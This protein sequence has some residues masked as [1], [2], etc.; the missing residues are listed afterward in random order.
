MLKIVGYSLLIIALLTTVVWAISYFVQP[1]LPANINNAGILF[2][3]ALLSVL[4]ALAAFKDIIELIQKF[5]HNPPATASDSSY[6]SSEIR[7]IENLIEKIQANLY[8]NDDQLP[9]VLTLA[10]DLCQSIN[11][12]NYKM[13]LEKELHGY[14]NYQNFHEEFGNEEEFER[15]MDQWANYRLLQSYVDLYGYM[16]DRNRYET[17]EFPYKTVLIAYSLSG[18][19]R[20]IKAAREARVDRVSRPIQEIGLETLSE[21]VAFMAKNEIPIRPDIDT[22]VYFKITDL[23]KI[24]ASVRK[25]IL[26]LLNE[27]QNYITEEK[28]K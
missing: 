5:F 12:L 8:G 25:I 28:R 10:L 21:F 20:N 16:V 4:G 22:V 24:L 1:I 14:E 3:I 13:W 2:F 17:T 23:E 26:K 6:P 9:Y 11:S 7:K 15:W 19:I 18:L 27:A